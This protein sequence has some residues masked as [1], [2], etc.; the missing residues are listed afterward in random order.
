MLGLSGGQ[1]QTGQGGG[2]ARE[3]RITKWE[4]REEGAEDKVIHSLVEV[5]ST[6]K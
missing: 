3:D 4:R 1:G 2:E 6:F 5:Q